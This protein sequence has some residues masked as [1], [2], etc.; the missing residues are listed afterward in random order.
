[1]LS[2]KLFLQSLFTKQGKDWL[3]ESI[4]GLSTILMANVE[5]ISVFR[6][7]VFFLE[8]SFDFKLISFQ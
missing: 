2:K 5:P 8:G 6:V 4:L 7:F 3:I 1:M